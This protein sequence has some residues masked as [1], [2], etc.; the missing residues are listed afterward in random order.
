MFRTANPNDCS[1]C[2]TA[3]TSSSPWAIR[4]RRSRAAAL[5]PASRRCT[6][7]SSSRLSKS[8][9]VSWRSSSSPSRSATRFSS[10]SVSQRTSSTQARG[11]RSGESGRHSPIATL[12]QVAGVAYSGRIQH[13]ASPPWRRKTRNCFARARFEKGRNRK[14][15]RLN[16]SNR[17]DSDDLVHF[18]LERARHKVIPNRA[19][20]RRGEPWPD[21]KLARQ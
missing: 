13:S 12:D 11:N 4:R 6:S 16:R 2:P 20:E 21:A 14:G 3:S 7:S 15:P 8:A 1:V 10:S 17:S 18:G 5:S 19:L 9:A